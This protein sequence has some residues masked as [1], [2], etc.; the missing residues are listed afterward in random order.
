MDIRNINL[1]RCNLTDLSLPKLFDF[2]KDQL[3]KYLD[4]EG[5]PKYP[6]E[7]N[8]KK[9][10]VILKD[11]I[12]RI[13]E[14]LSE[15]YESLCEISSILSDVGWNI[16]LIKDYKPILNSLQNANEEQAD[17]M[18]F[19]ITLMMYSN[20]LPEDILSYIS[21][22]SNSTIEVKDIDGIMSY[23]IS[24]LLNTTG[25]LTSDY[26]LNK[27]YSIF[28]I[29]IAEELELDYYNINSYSPGFHNISQISM[30]I[31]VNCLWIITYNLNIARNCL[32][33]RPWKQTSVMTK[34]LDFQESIVRSFIMYMGYL[35]ISGFDGN[36]IAKLFIRKQQLNLWRISTGY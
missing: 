31:Q 6:I 17:A 10:Q 21:H 13:Q 11:F 16:S 29:N 24:M 27:G 18:G 20:I 28:D 3:D 15:G 22:D 5:L 26:L 14:E 34:E 7:V 4:I 23:G 35:A 33:N 19:F 8:T 1:E 12:S 30:D 9:S 36:S 32:K 2:G 25:T